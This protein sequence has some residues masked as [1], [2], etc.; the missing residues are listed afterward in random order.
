MSLRYVLLTHFPDPALEATLQKLRPMGPRVVAH[1]STEYQGV[2]M[3]LRD[4]DIIYFGEETIRVLHTPGQ[5][6]CAVTYWWGDRLFTGE[7]LL[8]TGPGICRQGGNIAQQLRSINDKLLTF[9]D[10]YLVFPG[11]ESRKRRVAC[12]AEFRSALHRKSVR[13]GNPFHKAGPQDHAD[14][15][16]PSKNPTHNDSCSLVGA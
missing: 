10:E 16:S 6:P 14:P 7:T 15:A 8:A 12:I 9:P 3:R 11:R 13:S 5:M 2:D 1:E 4:D